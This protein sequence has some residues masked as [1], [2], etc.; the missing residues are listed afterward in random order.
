MRARRR[1]ASH[2]VSAMPDPAEIWRTR[3][4]ASRVPGT[5]FPAA[6]PAR[7]VRSHAPGASRTRWLIDFMGRK[8][9][10]AE[11]LHGV[12]RVACGL[13]TLGIGKGDRVGLFLPNVPHYVAA[14][15]GALKARR[16][17][18]QFLAAL[19]G[20]RAGGAGRGQRHP[21]P[22]HALGAR[23]LLPTALEVL[24]KSSLE[25][26]DRRLGRGRAAAGQ[27]AALPPV[28]AQRDRRA[29]RS[30]PRVTAFSAADR[31]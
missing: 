31:Q 13:A 7:H 30:D 21:A 24:E 20:R 17:R 10:Y 23:R 14:Y 25:R 28:Q 15:Y 12:N 6:Q 1:T 16:D 11:T 18:R 9:S 3:L 5:G 19:H 29:A 8:Y 26:L 22:L 4:S 2:L 27:V